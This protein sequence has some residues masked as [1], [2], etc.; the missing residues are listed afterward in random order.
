MVDPLAKETI[1]TADT[2]W[3]KWKWRFTAL[4]GKKQEHV[5]GR[6]YRIS[7]C[8]SVILPFVKK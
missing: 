4:K 2:L 8:L 7:S 6:R 1:S 3:K 5:R